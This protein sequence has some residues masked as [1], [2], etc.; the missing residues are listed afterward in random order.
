MKKEELVAA[1]LPRSLVLDLKKIENA[2]QSDRS[3][4][5]RK[6][7]YRAVTDWKKE[8]AAKLYAEGKVTLERAAMDSGASVR[9]M[10]EYLKAR[11]VPA[12]YDVEDLEEDMRSFYERVG[13]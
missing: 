4:V 12:Q 13:R 11:K 8:H 10:M 5:L 9:E 1:R 3:T 2:E 6:L 7:L